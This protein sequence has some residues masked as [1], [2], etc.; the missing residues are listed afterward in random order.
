MSYD[1]ASQ[2]VT[3][4]VISKTDVVPGSVAY[5]TFQHDAF[6]SHGNSGGPLFD[7]NG[8]LIGMNTLI[9]KNSESVN[10]AIQIDHGDP[11]SE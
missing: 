4:G 5:H 6:I 3:G 1:M 2:T 7:E 11:G 10:F 9:H 8:Y